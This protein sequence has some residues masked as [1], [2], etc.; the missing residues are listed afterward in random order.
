MMPGNVRVRSA[1]AEDVPGIVEVWKHFMDFHRELDRY[2]QRSEDGGDHFAAFV[3][4]QIKAR[5]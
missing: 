5:G 3:R 4:D 2:H 1:T